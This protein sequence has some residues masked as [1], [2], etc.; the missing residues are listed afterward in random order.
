MAWQK[1]RALHATRRISSAFG[2]LDFEFEC[3]RRSMRFARASVVVL[4]IK[5]AQR[6]AGIF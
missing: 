1:R 2:K 6:G 4:D 3:R 5:I